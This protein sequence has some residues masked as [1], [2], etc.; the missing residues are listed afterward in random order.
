MDP[1]FDTSPRSQGPSDPATIWK[2][3]HLASSHRARQTSLLPL[4]TVQ[5]EGL[6][7]DEEPESILYAASDERTPTAYLKGAVRAYKQVDKTEVLMPVHV[8]GPGDVML[9]ADDL[10]DDLADEDL[11]ILVADSSDLIVK[12]NSVVMEQDPGDL[13]VETF[14]QDDEPLLVAHSASAFSWSQTNWIT[15][16]ND[17]D[18]LSDTSQEILEYE[19]DEIL[20][21]QSS[22]TSYGSAGEE[23]S[24]SQAYQTPRDPLRPLPRSA[25]KALHEYALDMLVDEDEICCS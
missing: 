11:A 14:M 16:S 9:E 24:Q 12:P 1:D 10:T 6:L 23:R 17:D 8:V 15:S 13:P 2:K 22:L 7:E 5:D 25:Q 4:N 21:S 20:S 18:I 3:L 19:E